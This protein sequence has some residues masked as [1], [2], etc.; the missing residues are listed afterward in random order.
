[1]FDILMVF[2][3][4]IF[5]KDELEK[6]SA[7]DKPREKLNKM[8][9]VKSTKCKVNLDLFGGRLTT[10]YFVCG[11]MSSAKSSFHWSIIP[12]QV[13]SIKAEVTYFK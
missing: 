6:K 4:E 10:R 1:M 9:I 13:T 7:H 8:Q 2:L 12:Y 11:T 5:E 3:K